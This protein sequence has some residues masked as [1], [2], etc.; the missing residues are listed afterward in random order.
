MESIFFYRHIVGIEK[1]E[2]I[3]TSFYLLKPETEKNIRYFRFFNKFILVY[4]Y[5]MSIKEDQLHAFLFLPHYTRNR[6]EFEKYIGKYFESF[7]TLGT[8]FILSFAW[9]IIFFTKFHMMILFLFFPQKY[10]MQPIQKFFENIS[11]YKM[12]TPCEKLIPYID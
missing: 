6:Q 10:L 12:N 3:Y 2:F 1:N 8:P 5:Y 9:K 11:V 4:S 7:L